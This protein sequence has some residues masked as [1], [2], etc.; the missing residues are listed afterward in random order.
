MQALL[1]NDRQIVFASKHVIKI[2]D[3]SYVEGEQSSRRRKGES[4]FPKCVKN[5]LE[6]DV[7]GNV[8]CSARLGFHKQVELFVFTDIFFQSIVPTKLS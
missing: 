5:Y 7:E 4:L 6:T 2:D 3:N 1:I 8:L